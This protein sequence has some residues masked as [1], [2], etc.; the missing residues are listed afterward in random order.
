MSEENYSYHVTSVSTA[1][2][3]GN[4]LGKS[5]T[6]VIGATASSAEAYAE[7]N[8]SGNWLAITTGEIFDI[9]RDLPLL[10]AI[11]IDDVDR[12][13]T[14]EELEHLARIDYLAY[15]DLTTNIAEEFTR[16]IEDVRG[17]PFPDD[18]EDDEE[19]EDTPLSVEKELIQD[20]LTRLSTAI[21]KGEV[22]TPT[23][24]ELKSA[25]ELAEAI[26]KAFE[27]AAV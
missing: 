6:V 9:P 12:E 8:I 10:T 15:S 23:A 22:E 25:L 5:V 1:R 26:G 7:A 19:D 13:V 18:E 16:E 4:E 20:F 11:F 17:T 21:G 24:E 14:N 3:D 27:K 2:Y